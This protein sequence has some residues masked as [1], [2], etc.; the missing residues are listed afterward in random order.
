MTETIRRFRR[1]PDAVDAAQYEPVNHNAGIILNWIRAHGGTAFSAGELAWRHD[2][3]TYWH[4]EHGFIYV[5]QGARV[6]GGKT[7]SLRDDE[8]IVRT[9]GGSY[10]VVFPGDYVVR[11]QSGFYPLSAESFHRSYRPNPNHRGLT[12]G[13]P[14]PP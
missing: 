9:G 10:A 11:S 1:L 2:A 8:L 5:P 7:E 13:S 4:R 12:P 14:P 6:P 3:G